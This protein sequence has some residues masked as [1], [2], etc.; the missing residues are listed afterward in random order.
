MSKKTLLLTGAT[1]FVGKELFKSINKDLFDVIFYNRDT[2]L[3][4][5][6]NLDYI[7]HLAGKAHD[8]N[9]TWDDF[10]K[11]NIDLTRKLIDFYKHDKKLKFI[12]F[13]SAKVYGEVSLNKFKET[14]IL[15]P[16]SDYGKSKK[17]AE[18]ELINS[19]LEYIVFRPTL[20]FSP[21]AKGNLESLRKISKI[22]FPLPSNINNKRSLANLDFVVKNTVLALEEKLPWNQVYNLC[23]M[24]LSTTEIFRLNGIKFLIPYPSF[25]MRI[26]SQKVKEKILMNF[27]LDN[28]K[29][30]KLTSP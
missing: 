20:I 3:S 7:I 18:E 27:E 26:L 13:S 15:N 17:I 1:G 23:D 11:N 21:H 9:A 14:D 25:V 16:T 28:S 22:G 19:S 10:K 8:K 12:Y 29:I 30:L 5:I 4:D 6:D 24:T 2:N